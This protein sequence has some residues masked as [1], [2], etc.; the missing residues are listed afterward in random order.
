MGRVT[1]GAFRS[2]PLGILVAESE[3]SSVKALLDS[4]QA[5]YAQGHRRIAV[6]RGDPGQ[7]TLQLGAEV[8]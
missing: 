2:T 7:E 3:F 8:A 1:L 5:R 6:V 4:R